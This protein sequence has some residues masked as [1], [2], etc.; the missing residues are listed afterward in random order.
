MKKSQI[1]LKFLVRLILGIVIAIPII[2]FGCSLFRLSSQGTEYYQELYK[3]IEDVATKGESY[4][5]SLPL[6]MDKSTQIWG[7]QAKET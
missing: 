4:A 5:D 1:P 6:R 2:M 3:L 7:F